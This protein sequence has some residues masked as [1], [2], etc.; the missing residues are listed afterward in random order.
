MV[1]ALF[2]DRPEPRAATNPAESAS[3]HAGLLKHTLRAEI[4]D[5][6]LIHREDTMRLVHSSA[7][8]VATVVLISPFVGAQG[9][10]TARAVAGGGI[11]APGWTG[12]IDANEEKAGQALNIRR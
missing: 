2:P 11:S 12:K 6:I 3:C 1:P 7:L 5:H 4:T 8:A 9:Q 10:E